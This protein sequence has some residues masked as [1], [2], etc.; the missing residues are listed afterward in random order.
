MAVFY[1]ATP[2]VIFGFVLNEVFEA[3]KVV[4]EPCQAWRRH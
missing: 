1:K 4:A 3:D 2:C